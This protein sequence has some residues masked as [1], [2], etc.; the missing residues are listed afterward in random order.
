[1][2]T[3]LKQL[4]DA[5]GVGYILTPYATCPW[6]AYDGEKGIT[7]SAEVRM[8]NDGTEVEAEL[9]FMYDS[10]KDGK[11]MEQMMWVYFKPIVAG[12]WS[13]TSLR[14][15]GKDE[16]GSVY[17]WE[18]KSCNL[19]LACVTDLKM[20]IVPDFDALLDREMGG[21]ERWQDARQGGGSKAPKIKPQAL[22]GMKNGRGF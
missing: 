22:L 11:P 17:D 10:P 5:L 1:M 14:I 16:T 4:M 21:G 12:Q 6:S 15:K 13:P 3:D 20:D 9:Q 8:N 18:K 7:A 19:F 2:R